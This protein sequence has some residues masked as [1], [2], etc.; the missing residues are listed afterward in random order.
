[1]LLPKN[2]YYVLEQ[3]SWNHPVFIV[4]LRHFNNNIIRVLF[5]AVG[6]QWNYLSSFVYFVNAFFFYSTY[7]LPLWRGNNRRKVSAFVWKEHKKRKMKK[8]EVFQVEIK[9]F[10]F[11][12]T[13][14]CGFFKKANPSDWKWKCWLIH[15]VRNLLFQALNIVTG[16]HIVYG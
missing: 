14:D 15:G 5:L 4:I 13:E 3:R 10:C 11:Y 7:I 8:Q 16:L 9:T 12:L 1:M 6:I 2:E